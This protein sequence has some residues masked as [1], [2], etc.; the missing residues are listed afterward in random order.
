[1][2]AVVVIE[3]TGKTGTTVVEFVVDIDVEAD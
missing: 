2:C 3:V 1:M